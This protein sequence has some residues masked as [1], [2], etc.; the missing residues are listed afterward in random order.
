MSEPA[1]LVVV[2]HQTIFA[3]PASPW[4][5][6]RFAET[7]EPVRRLAEAFGERVVTTRWVTPEP[8]HGSW[9][10]YFERWPFADRPADDPAFDLVETTVALGARHTVTEPAFGKWGQQLRAITGPAPH[11]VLAGVATDCCVIATAIPAADA[12]ATVTVVS[13]ACAGSSDVGHTRALEVMAAFDPQIVVRSTDE[14]LRRHA[15]R[16]ADRD[17]HHAFPQGQTAGR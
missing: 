2:D 1:W 5:A 7:V 4:A 14:V 6:P 15:A 12:G 10:A 11:L 17:M 13:D 16:Y 8:K 3:D 9:Q